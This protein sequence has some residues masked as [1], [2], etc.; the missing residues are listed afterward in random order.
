M[1]WY[2]SMRHLR[3][4]RYLSVCLPTLRKNPPGLSASQQYVL[5]RLC[6]LKSPRGHLFFPCSASC[7]TALQSAGCCFLAFQRPGKPV[8]SPD[9]QNPLVHSHR[10]CSWGERGIKHRAARRLR[11][12]VS[13]VQAPAK[14]LGL[15]HASIM[16]QTL[17]AGTH[18]IGG[19][20][21]DGANTHIYFRSGRASK[22]ESKLM[23]ARLSFAK[24]K[25]GGG[26]SSS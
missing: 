1:P 15:S 14:A 11:D 12:R 25:G 17:P 22:D 7:S 9:M 6:S 21:A 8:S 24:R 19:V 5:C 26:S 3:S 16:L 2:P 20:R 4:T 13:P 18:I 23:K 10:P